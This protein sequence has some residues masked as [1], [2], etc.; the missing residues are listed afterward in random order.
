[1]R[2]PDFDAL[3]G[4]VKVTIKAYREV[5]RALLAANTDLRMENAQLRKR[6]EMLEALGV[7]LRMEREDTNESAAF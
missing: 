4:W 7:S 6:L 2:D 5:N 3:P 1:M